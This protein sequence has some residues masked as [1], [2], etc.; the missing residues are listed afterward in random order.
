MNRNG[1]ST[2]LIFNF[3]AELIRYR[4]FKC[5]CLD[6]FRIVI[7]CSKQRSSRSISRKQIITN[8][9]RKKMKK[10]PGKRRGNNLDVLD[11]SVP[12]AA[13]ADLFIYNSPLLQNIDSICLFAA[14]DKVR[15]AKRWKSI[16]RNAPSSDNHRCYLFC[17]RGR[18]LSSVRSITHTLFR[19][20]SC[21]LFRATE[22]E[23]R[24]SSWIVSRENAI[25]FDGGS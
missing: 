2:Y 10:F 8:N 14:N 13:Y 21:A 24:A 3:D 5:N 7:F 23:L 20:V 9:A 19:G 15:H 25:S 12:I 17:V 6:N 11:T 16:D 1:F 4:S 22:R 18:V